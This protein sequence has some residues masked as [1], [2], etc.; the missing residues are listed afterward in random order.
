M[1]S[2]LLLK[3][4]RTL[5]INYM[6]DTH[7]KIS[8]HLSKASWLNETPLYPNTG[9]VFLKGSISITL[10]SLL[11]PTVSDFSTLLTAARCAR[12]HFVSAILILSG[13]TSLSEG[14]FILSTKRNLD[15]LTAAFF[16]VSEPA[17][18]SYLYWFSLG[19]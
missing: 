15:S 1:K 3:I 12:T 7:Y 2:S 14:T 16:A 6:N 17:V 8:L 4:D 9:S 19:G 10:T 5:Q 13:H 11:P 18:D